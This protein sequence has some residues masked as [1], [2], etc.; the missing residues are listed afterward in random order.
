MPAEEETPSTAG[1]V[2]R[3]LRPTL[4]LR[5]RRAA[6][7]VPRINQSS[8]Q[9]AA[10]E[11]EEPAAASAAPAAAGSSGF[12]FNEALSWQRGTSAHEAW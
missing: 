1:I 7:S 10:E 8:A 11:D 12:G 4:L 3:W 2:S 9:C 6:T 5:R